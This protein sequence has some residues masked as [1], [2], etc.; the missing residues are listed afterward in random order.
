MFGFNHGTLYPILHR[1]E[2][3]GLISGSWSEDGG[4]RRRKS[5]E[6]TRKGAKHTTELL[7]AWDEFAIAFQNAVQGGGS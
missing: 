3:A 2:K 6:L 5:Y 4:G 7:Q 1:L